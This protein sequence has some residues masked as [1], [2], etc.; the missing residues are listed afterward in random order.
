M[1]GEQSV[2]DVGGFVQGLGRGDQQV[3]RLVTALREVSATVVW[4]D[5]PSGCIELRAILRVTPTTRNA[6]G[7]PRYPHSAPPSIGGLG[8]R[9]T[10]SASGSPRAGRRVS[11]PRGRRWR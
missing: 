11:R 3:A 4:T 10:A 5:L 1:L 8:G 7:P 2:K 9:L 6:R